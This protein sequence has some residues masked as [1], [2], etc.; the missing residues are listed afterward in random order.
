MGELARVTAASD[1]ELV[2]MLLPVAYRPR[3]ER[4]VVGS[5]YEQR[6]TTPAG[7]FTFRAREPRDRLKRATD[8]LGVAFYD[9][10]DAFLHLLFQRGLEVAAWSRPRDRHFSSAAHAAIAELMEQGIRLGRVPG[11]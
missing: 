2:V 8:S 3:D 6:Y 1:A 9:P 5:A 7:G 10:S 4:F 11:G